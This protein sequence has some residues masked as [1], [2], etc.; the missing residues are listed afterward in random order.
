MATELT[1]LESKVLG[2]LETWVGGW[3]ATSLAK[4]GTARPLG[5]GRAAAIQWLLDY[6]SMK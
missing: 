1:P 6:K 2:A 3:V 5:W 4:L